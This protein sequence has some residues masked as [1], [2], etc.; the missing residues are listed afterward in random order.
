MYEYQIA[1]GAALL[2]ARRPGWRENLDVD[3]LDMGSV[4][5]CVIGQTLG[6][7]HRPERYVGQ[8]WAAAL[9]ELSGVLTRFSGWLTE[10]QRVWAAEHGFDVRFP[11]YDGGYARL[12][13]EWRTYL[14]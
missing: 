14:R 12:T 10:S 8:R 3:D 4:T 2:D 5:R 9:T 6:V 13:D 1:R 7:E 11:T